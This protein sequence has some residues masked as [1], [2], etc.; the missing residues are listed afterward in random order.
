MNKRSKYYKYNIQV[1]KETR[2]EGY[3]VYVQYYTPHYSINL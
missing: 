2:E 3:A 1:S